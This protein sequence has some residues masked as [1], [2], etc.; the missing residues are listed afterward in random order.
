MSAPRMRLAGLVV[1]IAGA[2][3]WGYEAGVSG[4][5]HGPPIDGA[6]IAFVLIAMGLLLGAP[7][8]VAPV[9]G[10]AVWY[11]VGR[12]QPDCMPHDEG[13]KL[14]VVVLVLYPALAAVPVLAGTAA[15]RVFVL[16]RRRHAR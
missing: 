11:F 6:A 1:A 9:V 16:L 12:A 14:L 15:R 8:V 2:I 7:A 4:P 10:C 3:W 13:C 5:P